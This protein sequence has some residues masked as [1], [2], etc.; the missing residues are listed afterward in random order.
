MHVKA[1]AAPASFAQLQGDPPPLPLK[2]LSV[3]NDGLHSARHDARAVRGL[4]PCALLHRGRP[5]VIVHIFPQPVLRSV[6]QVDGQWLHMGREG[7]R[8][9]TEGGKEVRDPGNVTAEA[10]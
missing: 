1:N 10:R 8:E 4:A 6:Q 5:V 9:G 3:R 2:L 7:E